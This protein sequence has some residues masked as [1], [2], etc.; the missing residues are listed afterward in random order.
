MMKQM[1]LACAKITQHR[2]S[3]ILLQYQTTIFTEPKNLVPYSHHPASLPY[4]KLQK[5]SPHSHTILFK[6][7][8]FNIFS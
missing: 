6:Y 3:D 7:P 4:P 5:F 8:T 1:I 2:H